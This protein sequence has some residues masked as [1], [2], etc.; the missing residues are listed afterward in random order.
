V[1]LLE[2]FRL[3][4]QSARQNLLPALLLQAI[5]LC[6]M[7]A[8][9]LHGGTRLFLVDVGE[10]KEEMGYGF[11]LAAYMVSGALLPELLRIL[12]FQ[13]GRLRRSNI[14]SFAITAPLW[15]AMGMTVD[16]FYRCQNAW[17]GTGNEWT[18]IVTKVLVDQFIYSPF[19]ANPLVTG[20]LSSRDAGF[21][22]ASVASL[23]RWSFVTRKMLP[24][25]IA[26]W[27]VWMPGVC[28]VYFMP[29]LL[30]LPVAVLIQCFWVLLLTTI[31]EKTRIQTSSP[32]V[33]EQMPL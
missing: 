1:T 18:V 13:K 21:T 9:L 17:F 26:G 25:Q 32:G 2:S 24:V 11:A 23:F 29:P 20:Y 10:L 5:M 15:G 8:Y 22:R 12:F 28:F 16:F 33:P 4:L 3:G 19:F 27:C 7:A 14:W 31:N 6:L 30:Q